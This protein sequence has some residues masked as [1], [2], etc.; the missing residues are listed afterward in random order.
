MEIGEPGGFLAW[1]TESLDHVAGVGR[2]YHLALEDSDS[3]DPVFTAL[4]PA[5]HHLIDP[6]A[7]VFLTVAEDGIEFT[8][9]FC[10]PAESMGSM[11]ALVEELVSSGTFAWALFQNHPIIVAGANENEWV[12]LHSMTTPTRV[13]GL[14]VARLEQPSSFVPDVAQKLLTLLLM[15]A[16]SALEGMQHHQTREVLT[17][18]LERKIEARSA[19]LR[20][21]EQVARTASEA[22][23]RFLANVSHD[24]RTPMNGILGMASLLLETNLAPD[25][26]LQAETIQRSGRRLLRLVDEILDMTDAESGALELDAADLDLRTL[27]ERVVERH[28]TAG[29]RKGLTLLLRYGSRVSDWVRGDETRLEQILENLLDN[30]IKFT[31]G[32]HVFVEVTQGVDGD[33]RLSVSD[34]G[35]GIAEKDLNSVFEKFVQ[36]DPVLARRSGGT[37]LG[38]AI[39]KELAGLMGGE[40]RVRS[41]VGK[42]SEFTVILPLSSAPAPFNPAERVGRTL[43]GD[44]VTVVA[45]S[46]LPRGISSE[47]IAEMGGKPDVYGSLSEVTERHGDSG[48]GSIL[49]LIGDEDGPPILDREHETWRWAVYIGP[50]ESETPPDG[51]DRVVSGLLTETRLSEALAPARRKDPVVMR[52]TGEEGAVIRL[53]TRGRVLLVE[54]DDVNARVGKL[55]LTRLGCDVEVAPSGEDAIALIMGKNVGFNLVL[56][57]CQ[58]AEMDGL[59]AT[60]AVRAWERTRAHRIPIVALTAHVGDE[61]RDECFKA[62]MDDFLSKPVRLDELEGVLDRWLPMEAAPDANGGTTD[63]PSL[64]DCAFDRGAALRQLGGDWSLFEEVLSVFEEIWPDL[65]ERIRAGLTTPDLQEVARAAHRLKGAASNLGA[66]ALWT[67]AGQL[68]AAGGNGDEVAAG[69]LFLA[70]EEEVGRF[71][72]SAREPAGGLSA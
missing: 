14:F 31:D 47:L 36:L 70:V 5:L 28:W 16:A 68:E 41:T 3:E 61:D 30:A 59:E 51:F 27:A 33:Y 72:A 7:L 71:L 10:H 15:N 66:V 46:H 54:D 6:A 11:E 25:Q 22:K 58:M 57:D 24:V 40:L 9:D 26:R 2:T 45:S 32:G 48:P 53:G 50:W 4:L 55:M 35:V 43:T 13:V 37:G 12:L 44:R 29:R 38:L 67:T 39:C 65:Q 52:S 21:A 62:G 19:A 18:D 56:M 8:P 20:R 63:C 23:R 42:G 69:R 64:V 49:V 1:L 34:T 17:Q 60:R